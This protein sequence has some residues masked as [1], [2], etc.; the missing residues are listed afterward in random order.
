MSNLAAGI[1]STEFQAFSCPNCSS[2]FVELI[3]DGDPDD[4][5]AGHEE[6]EWGQDEVSIRRSQKPYIRHV[7]HKSVFL[8]FVHVDS[9]VKGKSELNGIEPESSG[10]QY[11]EAPTL[12]HPQPP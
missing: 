2:G 10:I 6:D 5:L 11:K 9:P 3:E 1:T 4:V 7:M 12:H 8:P